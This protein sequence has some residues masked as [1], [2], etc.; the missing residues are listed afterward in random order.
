MVLK[1]FCVFFLVLEPLLR[2]GAVGGREAVA[3]A[4]DRDVRDVRLAPAR[5]V[6]DAALA[7]AYG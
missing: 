3:L 6:V 2:L 4:V 1:F 7:L 5:R